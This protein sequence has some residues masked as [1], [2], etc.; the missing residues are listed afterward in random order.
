M[1]APAIPNDNPRA[2]DPLEPDALAWLSAAGEVPPAPAP[3]ALA[4]PD[5]LPLPVD[6]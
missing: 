1:T 3:A 6:D 5:E 4:E 2:D